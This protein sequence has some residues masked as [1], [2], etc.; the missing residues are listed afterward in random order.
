MC[1]T[2]HC[3][4]TMETE[5]NSMSDSDNLTTA[6]HTHWQPSLKPQED[7]GVACVERIF[8]NK[9]QVLAKTW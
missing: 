3:L 2:D 6:S 5:V 4:S 1:K 8:K 7:N 9:L